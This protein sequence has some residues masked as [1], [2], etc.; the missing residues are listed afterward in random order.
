MQNDMALERPTEEMEQSLVWSGTTE[1]D[2][3]RVNDWIRVTNKRI[4]RRREHM[5][6]WEAKIIDFQLRNECVSVNLIR[7]LDV[8]RQE[9]KAEIEF[10]QLYEGCVE[11]ISIGIEKEAEHMLLELIGE[12]IV[13]I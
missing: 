13:E 7:E 10:Q 6:E 2:W 9:Y 8:R 11:E 4:R 12:A 5:D 3:E 1:K